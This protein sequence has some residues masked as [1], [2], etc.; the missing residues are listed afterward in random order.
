MNS[1]AAN[2][3]ERIQDLAGQRRQRLSPPGDIYVGRAESAVGLLKAD[4]SLMSS[5][6]VSDLIQDQAQ[7]AR[8]GNPESIQ[9]FF[10]AAK[11]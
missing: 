1:I 9:A 11:S 6:T 4:P 7:R 10:S 2:P 3:T 5:R 8:A